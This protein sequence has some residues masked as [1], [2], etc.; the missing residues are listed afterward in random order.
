MPTAVHS[1]ALAHGLQAV[2]AAGGFEVVQQRGHQLGTGPAERVAQGD[3]AP[4]RVELAGVRAE[5]LRPGQRDRR[6]GLVDLVSVDG[7]DGQAAAPQHLLGGRDDPGQHQQ[8]V[9]ARHREGVEPARGRRPSSAA[10]SSLMISAADAP[11]VSGEE[12]PAV[13]ARR[14]RG[15][16]LRRRGCSTRA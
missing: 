9:A 12:L 7:V 2:A 11:S 3:R 15:S 6:E 8:R 4:A 10:F 14:S 1:A 16:A 13:S 5:F